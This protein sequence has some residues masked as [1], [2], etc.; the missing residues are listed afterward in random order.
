M[1]RRLVMSTLVCAAIVFACAPRNRVTANEDTTTRKL[2]APAAISETS[3]GLA[4]TLTEAFGE[5]ATTFALEV[6]NTGK[7]TEVRFPNGMT[8]DFVVLDEK[9]REVWRWSAGR[10]FTQA[11]QTKQLKP[12]DALRYEA[13]WPDARPGT[14]RV[15]ASLNSATHPQRIEREFD[16][17]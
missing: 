17:R 12:G 4:F 8:H 15:I 2:A 3:H 13:R 10:L 11:L 9:D 16:V 6:K 7:R 5:S 1:N 14:Y